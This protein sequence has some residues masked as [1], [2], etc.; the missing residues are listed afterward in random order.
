MK[1]LKDVIGRKDNCPSCGI[2]FLDEDIYEYFIKT[3]IEERAE[4]LAALYGWSEEN[5]ICFRND[6]AVETEQYDGATW[7]M[8]PECNSYWKRFEWADERYLEGDE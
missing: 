6:I 8:C 4:E 2:S 3:N 1:I 7:Y 5:K